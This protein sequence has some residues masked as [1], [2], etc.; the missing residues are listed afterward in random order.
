LGIRRGD[1]DPQ[2]ELERVV[3]VASRTDAPGALVVDYHTAQS[4]DRPRREA[5]FKRH[6][7]PVATRRDEVRATFDKDGTPH[8]LDTQLSQRQY[9]AD[10]A[11]AVCL[12]LRDARSPWTLE[13]LADRLRQ[14]LFV[15]FAGRK[16]AAL[17]LP[18]EP[19]LVDAAN[20]VEALRSLRFSLDPLVE[21]VTRSTN[22]RVFRWEGD[23]PDL[24]RDRTEVRRDRV[25]SRARWQFVTRDEHVFTETLTKE[26]RDV[27]EPN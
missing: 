12:W 24:P 7:V 18:F 15:P 26:A 11:F 19:T 21:K 9:R 20:P 5:F 16:A 2:A 27:P 23:W 10:A 8:G 6:G 17:G 4:P 13:Q 14:P 22:E 1:A 25:L 3:G